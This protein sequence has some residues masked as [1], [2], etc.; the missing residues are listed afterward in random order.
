VV[1]GGIK[2]ASVSLAAAAGLVA[3]ADYWRE[4]AGAGAVVA[5]VVPVPLIAYWVYVLWPRCV[6]GFVTAAGACCFWR[7]TQTSTHS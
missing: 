2:L 6:L 7:R 4:V 3:S 1:Y 5:A